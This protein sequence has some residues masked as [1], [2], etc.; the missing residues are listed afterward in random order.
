V[1]NR[2]SR[3]GR[4]ITASLVTALLFLTA[5]F[6]AA[7]QIRIYASTAAAPAL[8]E[9]AVAFGHLADMDVKV[10]SGASA[11]MVRLMRVTRSGDIFISS[12]DPVMAEAESLGVIDGT[13]RV[14]LSSLR[15]ALYVPRGNPENIRSLGDLL[16]SR[17]SLAVCDPKLSGAGLS[18]DQW[19]NQWFLPYERDLLR[20]QIVLELPDSEGTMNAVAMGN[21]GA[22]V[23]WEV[24]GLNN[25]RVQTIP[26]VGTGPE[27]AG[28][29]SA[30]ISGYTHQKAMARAF[31]DYLLSGEGQGF[32]RKHGYIT[33]VV[34]SA[35]PSQAAIP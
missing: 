8:G 5:G 7:G 12:S 25:P 31:L 13:S 10:V 23:G 15:L 20:Q 26:M 28:T 34:P 18:T 35:P 29:L 27:S 14:R 33:D 4:L 21:V 3:R 32:F 2:R 30:A 6:A 19:L 11:T 24:L 16:G 22:G 9:A 1:G 17:V